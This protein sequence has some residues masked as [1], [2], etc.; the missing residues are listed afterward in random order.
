MTR[1]EALRKLLALGGLTEPEAR[2]IC[3]WPREEF[4]ATLSGLIRAGVV[5]Y[6]NGR[7]GVRVYQLT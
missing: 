2:D 3:G 4:N 5:T 7:H 6:L 1:A